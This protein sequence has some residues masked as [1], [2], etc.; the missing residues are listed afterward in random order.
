MDNIYK[1]Y[2]LQII[3]KYNKGTA[4]KE[5]KEFL[6]SYDS[7]FDL[8]DDLVTAENEAEF[9]DVKF[10]IKKTID[11]RI[12]RYQKK[13]P[14][15]LRPAMR[16]AAA[17]VIFFSITG[18]LYYL[19]NQHNNQ[20][21]SQQTAQN[22]HP[23]GNKAILVLANG[24]HITLDSVQN[25]QVAKQSNINITKTGGNQLVYAKSAT[26]GQQSADQQQ[27]TIITPN[28]GQYQLVLPDG[29]KVMLNAASSLSYPVDF[30]GN[31]RVVH[32]DGEAYFEVA[33]NKK[34]PFRVIAGIQT[35]EVLGTHFNINAYKDETEIKTTL[36]E[37]SVKVS[38]GSNAIRIAPGE[39]AVTGKN[40]DNGILKHVVDV[41]KETAWKN[42][43]FSFRDDDLKYV[44]RQVARWYDIKV[45]Y[46][47]KL[48]A[49]RYFGEIPR[50]SNLSDV[51]KILELNGVHFEV[52]NKT[53]T[54]SAEKTN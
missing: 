6:E 2:F 5:E 4:T 1:R 22:I 49:E 19:I 21:Q 27:N 20:Q 14:F 43:L 31:E 8:K 18:T 24:S 26:T 32:L 41:D 52:Q 45:A 3:N 15:Y 42:G 29:T 48:P 39:Q 53:V 9:D 13:Q 33:K 37:G 38:S 40:G 47:G 11:Q 44:M 25:G 7:I 50:S 12:D 34:M 54:I 28:G 51:F 30:S 23:G 10:S 36:L 17:V 16:Y 35:V 46:D